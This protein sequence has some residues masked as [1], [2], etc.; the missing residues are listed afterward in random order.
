LISPHSDGKSA[1]RRARGRVGEDEGV[2]DMAGGRGAVEGKRRSRTFMGRVLAFACAL[3]LTALGVVLAP[4]WTPAWAQ[5]VGGAS[6]TALN[7]LEEANR[8]LDSSRQRLDQIEASFTREDLTDADLVRLREGADGVASDLGEL[9]DKTK[10]RLDAAKSRVEQLGPKPDDKSPTPESPEA[11]AARAEQTKLYNDA[12]AAVKRARLLITQ[13]EQ[14]SGVA[15]SKRRELFAR[16]LLQRSDSIVSPKLWGAAIDDLPRDLR[17]ISTLASDWVGFVSARSKGWDVA[18]LLA[19]LLGVLLA[20]PW[21]RR[22]ARGALERRRAGA[23]PDELQKALYAGLSAVVI[24]AAPIIAVVGALVLLGEFGLTTPRFQPVLSAISDAVARVSVTAGL[25]WGLLAPGRP[26]WRMFDLSEPVVD[27]MTR[28]A[29]TIA[30]ILSVVKILESVFDAAAAALVVTVAIRGVGAVAVAAVLAAGLGTIASLRLSPDDDRYAALRAAGW[31]IAVTI[32]GAAL[33]GYI[34][35]AAFLVDQLAWIS[36]VVAT[37]YLALKI[38]SNGVERS[39]GP[40]GRVGKSLAVSIGARP[41]ALKQ[42]AVLTTGALSLILAAAA[43]GLIAAPWGIR[44]NDLLGYLRSIFTGVKIGDVT[45]SPSAIVGAIALFVSILAL[46]RAGQRWL[47]ARFLPATSL[48]QGLR[49][50][51]VTSVGYV[52]FLVA[53]TVSLGHLGLSFQ[54]I[55]IVAGALS[56]G[57]GLGLQSIVSNFVSG[58]IVLWERAIRV[59]DWIVVGGEQGYVRRINVRSTEIETFDRALVVMPNSNLVNGVVKNWVRGD[60]GGRVKIELATS[61]DVDPEKVREILIR[62][63]KADSSVERIPAPNVLFVAFDDLHL[64]FELICFIDDVEAAN[65]IKSDLHFEIFRA[66]REEGLAPPQSGAGEAVEMLAQAIAAAAR[67]APA[68]DGDD[69]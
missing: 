61:R 62:V 34:A 31:I 11:A 46:T 41:Q 14:L 21:L 26:E 44:S 28:M 67:G 6:P 12:D 29:M 69:R 25:V 38:V 36:G 56:V 40:E 60:R 9:L 3:V 10:P 63:A 23:K 37:T 52:G 15:V 45:L 22:L 4:S 64:K 5:T 55:A 48:D 47:G 65:R 17:A 39:L 24:A 30:L 54:N 35:L 13:A 57:V 1:L 58:L 8:A 20:A 51:I 59:G 2:I 68:H 49:D 53:A 50:A 18:I 32:A 42:M 33:F 27:R 43:I 66:F 7:T 16:A 19:Y